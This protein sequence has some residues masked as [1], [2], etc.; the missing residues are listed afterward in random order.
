MCMCVV[1][2]CHRMVILFQ[3]LSEGNKEEKGYR[4]LQER[5]RNHSGLERK[6]YTQ[7][8]K[9]SAVVDTMPTTQEGSADRKEEIS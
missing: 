3:L 8:E 1:I 9:N 5:Q 7:Q 6:Y 2:F 4:V